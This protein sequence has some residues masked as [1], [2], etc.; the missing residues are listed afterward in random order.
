[1]KK[2][3]RT[4]VVVCENRTCFQPA[5]YCLFYDGGRTGPLC[6]RH[7]AGRANVLKSQGYKE[8]RE[9]R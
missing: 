3:F 2:E 7:A 6:K 1:M 9:P 8:K 4:H 5:A